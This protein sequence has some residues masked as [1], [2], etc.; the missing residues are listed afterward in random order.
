M[1]RAIR[2]PNAH[3]GV[4]ARAI[5]YPQLTLRADGPGR[6]RGTFSTL[7]RL[8]SSQLDCKELVSN[9]LEES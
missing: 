3:L 2:I 9:F 1:A 5:T 8:L 7:M 4:M 6:P